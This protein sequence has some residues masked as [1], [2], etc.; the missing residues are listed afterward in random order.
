MLSPSEIS[1]IVQDVVAE[2]DVARGY[3]VLYDVMQALL[4][5]ATSGDSLRYTSLFTQLAMVCKQRGIQLRDIDAVRRR[6]ESVLKGDNPPALST[7]KTDTHI[8][9]SFMEALQNE[10]GSKKKHSKQ[11]DRQL[12]TQLSE[13]PA[14]FRAVV[15]STDASGVSVLTEFG[16]TMLLT[17]TELMQPTHSLLHKGL[18]LNLID[19]E[20]S[21]SRLCARYIIIEP[22][23][24]LDI[25]TLAGCMAYYG[26]TPQNYLLRLLS[27]RETSCAI[28]LGNV[29]NEFVDSVVHAPAEARPE[30]IQRAALRK[31]F[32]DAPLD[33]LSLGDGLGKGFARAQQEQFEHIYRGLHTDFSTPAIGL[34]REDLMLE[35]TLLCPALGLS[36]RLDMMSADGR[37]VVELKSGRA[38]ETTPLEPQRMHRMQLLLYAE[39]MR[40][41]FG[42]RPAEI[43]AYLWY[44]RYP[45]LMPQRRAYAAVT[46]ALNLRNRIV[47]MMQYIASHGAERVL[48]LL[49]PEALNVRGC[50]D[51]IYHRLFRPELER[52]CRPLQTL[53][54][55][56]KTYFCA[57]ARFLARELWMGKT[58]DGRPFSTRGFARTWSQGAMSKIASGEMLA[59]L[60]FVAAEQQSIATGNDTLFAGGSSTLS[61]VISFAID[62]QENNVTPSFRAGDAVILYRWSA[63]QATAINQPLYRAFVVDITSAFLRL[64]LLYPQSTRRFTDPT[65]RYAVEHDHMD[66]GVASGFE[67]L[68]HFAATSAMRRDLLLG[69]R[70][71]RTTA[72]VPVFV[73]TNPAVDNIVA[74]ALSAPDYFLLVGPPGTGKTSV[75][76]RALTLNFLAS[77]IY[78]KEQTPQPALLLTAYTNRAVDEICAMLEEANVRYVR[79][80]NAASCGEAFQPRLLSELVKNR[81]RHELR[82]LL[83]AVP[84]VVGTVLTLSRRM[85]LFRV[86][87]FA[88]VV[89]DE[90]SQ[91]LEPQLLTLLCATDDNGEPYLP[92]FV[93]VGDHKQLPAVVLQA[94]EQTVV[95]DA[96]LQRAGLFDLRSSLFERLYRLA[97]RDGLTSLVA[98]LTHQGRMHPDVAAYASKA[99]YGGALLPVPLP[100]QQ[101]ILQLPAPCDAWEHFAVSTRLGFID[102]T[103]A[104]ASDN[105][106]TNNPQARA[107]ARLIR[108]L[109][110]IYRRADAK[111]DAARQV[112]VIVPF[113]AQINR[114]RQALREQGVAQAEQMTIDTVEC[115]QGSQRDII[116]FCTTVSRPWQLAMISSP[117]LINGQQVDRKLNVATTRARLQFFMVGNAELLSRSSL[118]AALIK[119]S[120][121][122]D[123]LRGVL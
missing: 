90:A 52:V 34:R 27:P 107:T 76:L 94:E 95:S 81:S 26:E 60:R 31:A 3:G 73:T 80:G 68:W 123:L 20:V 46:D 42:V 33:F 111:F 14:G 66:V 115:Y 101:A 35:P 1:A 36:G 100:H 113:R 49:T 57:F 7:L 64:R 109:C 8:V 38:R 44:S 41:N 122:A 74:R 104:D 71:A 65:T 105:F 79:I 51:S 103:E 10:N 78:N 32:A 114:V 85:E 93:M 58:S 121:A 63:P 70:R 108:A 2:T 16:D 86:K 116:V 9:M 25:S 45:T 18:T 47:L 15:M 54:E 117:V 87:R 62:A 91:I 88:R 120:A 13:T 53:D 69:R 5:T 22:D 67:G 61:G 17:T 30:D 102:V 96:T 40:R 98:T 84:V 55:T 37:T 21:N 43:T 28:V 23:Y 82:V 24:L 112:G 110:D 99:F 97:Q 89:I 6:A 59:N 4:A 118:Y 83:D 77:Y 39:M 106:K 19:C 75:A 12:P 92:S 119:Q 29:A 72:P 11:A 50:D 56:A 48:K